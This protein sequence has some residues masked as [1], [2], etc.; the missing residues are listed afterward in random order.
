MRLNGG[1]R[2]GITVVIIQLATEKILE[3]KHP[4]GR[5]QVFFCGHP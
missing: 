3:L 1:G 4:V 5:L 2:A